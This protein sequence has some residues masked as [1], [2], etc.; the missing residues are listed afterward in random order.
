VPPGS[1]VDCMK[2]LD[3]LRLKFFWTLEDCADNLSRKPF[4]RKLN[5]WHPSSGLEDIVWAEAM[6]R[7]DAKYGTIDERIQ[8]FW[9]SPEALESWKALREIQRVEEVNTFTARY[10]F[11]EEE[12]GDVLRGLAKSG[13]AES[14][15]C[16]KYDSVVNP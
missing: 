16:T 7:A 1:G 14:I 8:S 2:P 10:D 11:I 4:F 5:R 9:Y 15:C 13:M 12:W 6:A 3:K